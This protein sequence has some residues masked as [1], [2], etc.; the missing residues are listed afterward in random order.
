VTY[1][2]PGDTQMTDNKSDDKTDD[3]TNYAK[4]DVVAAGAVLWR[5]A[6]DGSLETALVHRPRYDDWSLPKGKLERGETTPEA[7]LREVTEETGIS[8]A[9]GARLGESHYEV[10]QGAKVVHYW[11]ARAGGGEF[12]PNHEVD[13]LRWLG[14]DAA[15][16]LLTYVRDRELLDRFRRWELPPRPLLLVR[17]AKAGTRSDWSGEDEL[18][19]LTP[20]GRE[21]ASALSALLS[22]FGPARAYAAPPLRCPQTIQP[23]ADKLGLTIT[24]EPLLSE[25]S[26]WKDPDAGLARL[27]ELAAGPDV[28]VVCSQGGV[29]PDLV[30]RL[31]GDQGATSRK[32]S[33]WVL[34]FSGDRVVSADYYPAPG[35]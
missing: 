11:S 9:L 13:E 26:Y 3:V 19:P 7:A 15:G 25:D 28:P 23:L 14:L 18:R 5:P 10:P 4:P 21:Q 22:L 27:R 35:R 29:I 20:K 17:H 2:G 1:T 33:T 16:E 8:A 34:G 30:G 24:P 6:A 32:A 12:T 31:T